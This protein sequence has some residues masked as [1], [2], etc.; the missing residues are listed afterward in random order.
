MVFARTSR[1]IDSQAITTSLMH[2][3]AVIPSAAASYSGETLEQCGT[4]FC[5]QLLLVLANQINNKQRTALIAQSK[6]SRHGTE[7]FET[8]HA[9]DLFESIVK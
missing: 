2:I 9:R 6:K 7:H 5:Q 4:R 8:S 1:S 3:E